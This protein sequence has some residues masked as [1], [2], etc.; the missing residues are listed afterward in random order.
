MLLRQNMGYCDSCW[1]HCCGSLDDDDDD[2]HE[3]D[4]MLL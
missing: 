4:S 2:E 1:V 3:H